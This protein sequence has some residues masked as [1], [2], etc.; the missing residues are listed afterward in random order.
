MTDLDDVPRTSIDSILRQERAKLINDLAA[1]LD[2]E[3]GLREAMIAA[4][5]TNLVRDLRDVL[6]VDAG[7]SAIVPAAPTPFRPETG[8]ASAA[9]AVAS[10]GDAAA[11]GRWALELIDPWGAAVAGKVL[12]EYA[13]AGTKADAEALARRLGGLPLALHLAG[14]YLAETTS[15]PSDAAS[16]ITTF[17]DYRAAI[18]RASGQARRVTGDAGGGASE[19]NESGQAQAIIDRACE[20]SLGL[21]DSRGFS[22]A[23]L[24]LRVLA[25]FAEADIPLTVLDTEI[26]A[27]S[28]LFRG[29]DA[30]RQSRLVHSLAEVGLVDIVEPQPGEEGDR[31]TANSLVLRIHPMV[32]SISR[33][34]ADLDAQAGEYLRLAA[35][36]LYRAANSAAG[37]PEDPRTWP[38]WRTLAAHCT[39]FL[40]TIAGHLSEPPAEAVPQ[41]ASAA[42]RSARFQAARGLY[43]QAASE[44]R[45]VLRLLSRFP[46]GN[47]ADILDARLELACALR[48]DGQVQDAERELQAILQERMGL[49]SRE[50]QETVTLLD[51]LVREGG[52]THERPAL[53]EREWAK[54]VAHPLLDVFETR[55]HLA[56]ALAYR[57]WSPGDKDEYEAA[58]KAM[59]QTVYEAR[60]RMLGEGHPDTLLC[61]VGL[62][63]RLVKAGQTEKAE[64]ELRTIYESQRQL[65]ERGEHHPDTL[66]T[67]SWIASALENRDELAEAEAVYRDVC[68]EQMRILGRDHPQTLI[69]LRSL[70][71]LLRGRGEPG[72]GRGHFP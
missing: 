62:A 31:T 5:H 23:R 70:A 18:D 9:T 21:L 38:Q 66:A 43:D 19:E 14:N 6:D 64:H 1:V 20:L 22:E 42:L 39:S 58:A 30:R 27:N 50:D 33:S 28:A 63:I 34:R 12:R 67:L 65:P 8:T 10:H 36:L 55:Y 16:L 60:R 45:Q 26:I 29:Q 57:A 53:L 15:T 44:S 13:N 72:R 25:Y 2:V 4:R 40:C 41:A 56:V 71:Y 32:R 49:L 48:D 52:H 11:W 35:A 54:G 69:S 3:A 46:D 24:L 61:R 68:H 7:L 17:A 51:H 47:A 59:Y 37:D